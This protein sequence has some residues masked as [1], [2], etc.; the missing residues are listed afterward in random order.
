MLGLSMRFHKQPPGITSGGIVR[1]RK[2]WRGGSTLTFCGPSLEYTRSLLTQT[3]EPE[4][5]SVCIGQSSRG[6]WMI[7]CVHRIVWE[8]VKCWQDLV[9]TADSLK[10]KQAMTE[11]TAGR[12][13][14]IE[15]LQRYLTESRYT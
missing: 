2:S 12:V 7:V 14:V 6:D 11:S 9:G 10:F 8:Y 5:P 1:K 4:D 3:C 13:E 15:D